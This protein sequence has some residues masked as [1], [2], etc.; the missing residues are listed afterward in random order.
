MITFYGAHYSKVNFLSVAEELWTM[1]KPM[2]VTWPLDVFALTIIV[3]QSTKYV[4][5]QFALVAEKV[6]RR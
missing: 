3:D 1:V 2:T 5:F 4:Q 6:S